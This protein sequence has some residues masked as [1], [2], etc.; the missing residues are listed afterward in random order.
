MK[1][2]SWISCLFLLFT[3]LNAYSQSTL[4][5]IDPQHPDAR[6]RLLLTG[7]TES[8]QR[9]VTAAL[10]VKLAGDWKTYWRSPG[11]A[12]IAP[13][14]NWD[15]SEN[16]ESALWLW[17]VPERFELLGI[18][19]LGYKGDT[20]FPI[21]LIVAD[22]SQPVQL[23]GQLRLSTCTTIC[24]L[25]DY[26]INLE[27]TPSELSPDSDASFLVDKAMSLVPSLMPDTGLT[28]SVAYWNQSAQQLIVNASSVQGWESAD[29]IIDGPEDISFRPAEIQIRNNKLQALIKASSWQGN[30][31]LTG[32]DVNI[33]LINGRNRA[34][35]AEQTLPISEASVEIWSSQPSTSF[36]LILTFALLGGFILNLMPCVLPVLGLKLSSLV[37]ASGQSFRVTRQQFLSTTAGILTSFWLLA[38]FILLLKITG[39]SIGW[40][41]QFQNP[42][43]IGFMILITALFGANLFGLFEISLPSFLSTRISRMGDNSLPGHFIQGMFATLLATPCSAPFLGTAVAFAL[44]KDTMSLF[45]IFT[46][47][48]FGM[49]LPYVLVIINPALLNWIPK[50]G[51]WMITLRRVLGILL[52][53]TTLWLVSLLDVHLPE[54]VVLLIAAVPALL[55]VSQILKW[56]IPAVN[57]ARTPLAIASIT[58]SLTFILAGAWFTGMFERAPANQLPWQRLDAEKIPELVKA[59]KTVYVDITADWCVTC[60]ANKVRVID[61]DPV[62]SLLQQDNVVLMKGD[63]TRASDEVTAYLQKNG[64]F[65]VPLNRVYGPA[66][67]EG[68]DL[69]TLLSQDMVKE[70][71]RAASYR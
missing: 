64:R 6:V 65:G 30:V 15:S 54:A 48:G 40:G 22:M 37:K 39:N 11:E 44:S 71:L 57:Q 5:H 23:R 59:G 19:T 50:P 46:V 53:L 31:S 58:L 52:L 14:I 49:S 43:F 29:V 18:D 41:I 16:L 9:S 62:N 3:S 61:R 45:S 56:L 20:V 2:F 69:P 12:G 21:T 28:A 25:T 70:A 24:V 33:T 17:P 32:Q 27:F 66:L 35:A 36:W 63:W 7:E 13:T 67:P 60:Q 55:L 42:W 38:G 4:W 47:L 26:D 51:H 10:E 1:Y 68:V 34:Q 8:Q